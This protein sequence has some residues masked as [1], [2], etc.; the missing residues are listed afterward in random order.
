[1]NREEYRVNLNCSG[2]VL[3]LILI[4]S[5]ITVTGTPA[6]GQY[7]APREG[8]KGWRTFGLCSVFW[9]GWESKPEN[10]Y[11]FITDLV[12]PTDTTHIAVDCRA[13]RGALYFKDQD[14][15]GWGPW[16]MSGERAPVDTQK[17]VKAYC[18]SAP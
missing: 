7:V 8:W 1:M 6:F 4:T 5:I 10:K 14:G 16:L 17:V 18:S 13:A 3:K 15:E 9:D 2:L 11:V 12:C